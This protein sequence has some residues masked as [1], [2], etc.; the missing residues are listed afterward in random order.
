M[1]KN[2]LL[3]ERGIQM[4]WNIPTCPHV[5]QLGIQHLG[6]SHKPQL[7]MFR[8]D[9]LKGLSDIFSTNQPSPYVLP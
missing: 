4:G 2:R 5:L 6:K 1:K 7:R 9:E 8:E 3:S